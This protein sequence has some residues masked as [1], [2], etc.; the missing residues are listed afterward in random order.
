MRS[1]GHRLRVRVVLF[2]KKF[3]DL[4]ISLEPP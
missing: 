3:L 2:G 1:R 4:E